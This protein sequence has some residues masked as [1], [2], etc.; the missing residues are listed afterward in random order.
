MALKT[1]L[2]DFYRNLILDRPRLTLGGIVLI[3]LFFAA[4][5]PQFRLDASPDSLLLEGDT[6]LKT[7][8]TIK[9]RYGTDDFLIVTYTP[10]ADLFDSSTLGDLK[11]LRDKLKR[12][13]RVASVTSILDVPLVNSP[14]VTIEA[15]KEKTQTLTSPETNK[16]LARK[17]LTTSPLYSELI[18]SKDAQTAGIL[19]TFE[20]NDEWERILNQREKLR[21]KEREGGLSVNEKKKLAA[22]EKEYLA[23]SK[24]LQEAQKEDIATVRDIIEEHRDK[25]EIHLGGVKMIAVDSIEFVRKDLQVFGIAVLCFIIL[26]LT[27]FFRNPRW[28]ALPIFNCCT[29]GVIMFGFIGLVGWPITVVSSNFISLLLIFTLSFSVHQI[30]RYLEYQADNPQKD[31]HQLVR[32]STLKIIT[33][34]FFMVV[35]T[36]V[37]FGSLVVSDIRPV[38]DFGWIMAVGLAVSFLVSFTLFP[39]ALMLL[40]PL[41][42]REHKD[43]TGKITRFFANGIERHGKIIL[44]LFAVVIAFIAIGMKFLTVENRFIDYYKESTEI[45][46]GMKT[47]DKKLGGTVPLD[48]IVDAPQDFLVSYEQK[49]ADFIKERKEKDPDY[50]YSPSIVNGYWLMWPRKEMTEIHNYLDSLPETGKVLSFQTTMEMAHDLDPEA[51]NTILLATLKERLP[52]YVQDMLFGSYISPDGNQLRF[53]ARIY[54]TDKSLKRDELLKDINAHIKND[55]GVNAERFQISGMLVLYN[56]VLQSLFNSQIK[57]VWTVFIT[58][59]VMFSILFRSPYIAAVAFLPNVMI[60]VLVLGIMGWFHIP[61]DIMTITIAAIC[62]GSADDNTI[63]YVHRFR[64]EFKKHGDYWKAV[65]AS[66]NSIGRAMYYTSVTIMLGFSLLMFS[67]FVPTIYFGLLTAFAMFLAIL[68]NLVLL[69]L[70]L[71]VFRPLGKSAK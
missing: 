15:F 59:F 31:Q 54:E 69:P 18:I 49:K 47:I 52:P 38:I 32:D 66:H 29:V 20:Q 67:N 9:E 48:I 56:N 12:L 8:R 41:E 17:E 65:H 43:L 22:V 60:T 7:Y 46:Q 28:V 5:I 61:L 64:T 6:A 26:L 23:H 40:K 11:D 16:E 21:E 51:A 71:V 58:I 10:R 19:V 42:P 33:P 37:A 27:I 45:H 3:A 24:A 4:F 63:H 39:S 57:T 14:P 34:C 70:L 30:V 53:N 36:I 55:I 25:A 44:A 1:Y 35:T 2:V 68:A 50:I 62:T 13:G